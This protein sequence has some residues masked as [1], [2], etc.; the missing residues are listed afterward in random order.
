MQC[1][2]RFDACPVNDANVGS[3]TPLV[4]RMLQSY[5][6]T[7]RNRWESEWTVSRYY[8]DGLSSPK[9]CKTPYKSEKRNDISQLTNTTVIWPSSANA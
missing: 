2:G 8:A 4:N 9:V 3:Y 5:E 6:D 1:R 7:S